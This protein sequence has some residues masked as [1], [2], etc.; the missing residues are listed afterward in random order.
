MIGWAKAGFSIES[1]G[2]AESYLAGTSEFK[3]NLVHSNTASAIYR[4]DAN[5][6][7]V[8]TAAAMQTKAES[9]GCITLASGDDAKL[10]SPYYSTSPN[11]LPA[12]GS[13]ALTGASFTGMNAFFTTVA[14]RGAMGTT[15]WT[16]KWTNWDP[17]NKAY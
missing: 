7:A 17:Q 16:D 8:I 14:F 2:T 10:T 1:K 4:G 5:A 11:F 6:I 3:N 9:E 13:P 15:N 12:T